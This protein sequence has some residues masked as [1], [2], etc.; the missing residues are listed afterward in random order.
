[1]MIDWFILSFIRGLV[2]A[3]VYYGTRSALHWDTL[4]PLCTCFCV[5]KS[6][7]RL[8]E[9][10]GNWDTFLFLGTVFEPLG[11]VWD[12]FLFLETVFEP[13]RHVW[14]TFLFI[15]T[16]SCLLGQVL[17]YWDTF[18][19]FGTHSCV[20]GHIHVFWD[21]FLFFGTHS[22]FLRHILVNRDTFLLNRDTFL[23]NW[24]TCLP[25]LTFTVEQF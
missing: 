13:L 11:H 3:E 8:S 17:V 20:L 4:L 10:K 6:T 16:G 24:D 9:R 1:M 14:D 2:V 19:F 12:T 5:G 15:G 23:H 22:C 18:L 21:T 25:I 7:A